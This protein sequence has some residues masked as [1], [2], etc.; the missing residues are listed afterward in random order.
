MIIIWNRK[1]L[2]GSEKTDEWKKR[3]A[4][5]RKRETQIKKNPFC[6]LRNKT[7]RVGYLEALLAKLSGSFFRGFFS[8][9]CFSP[10]IYIYQKYKPN[11]WGPTDCDGI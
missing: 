11:F 1:R 2:Q 10:L 5:K 3:A 4:R 9:F 8:P 7:D 6:W